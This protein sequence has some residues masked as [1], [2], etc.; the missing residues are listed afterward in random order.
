MCV[1][2]RHAPSARLTAHDAHADYVKAA[3]AGGI[4][5]SITHGAVTPLD[6]VKTRIQLDPVKCVVNARAR[7]QANRCAHRYNQGFVGGF[8]QVLSTEGAGALFTGLGATAT[9]YFVQGWFKF[10][11]VEFFK[12]NFASALGVRAPWLLF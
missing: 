9:G 8:R 12:I 2:A 3:A 6:V 4:C 7:K 10:G 1:D 11:G 5:C